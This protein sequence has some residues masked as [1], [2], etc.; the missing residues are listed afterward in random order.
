[1][2]KATGLR[3]AVEN[4]AYALAIAERYFGAAQ[5]VDDFVC[6]TLGTGVGGGCYSNGRLIRG[7]HNLANALGHI[8]IQHKGL[9]CSCGQP[10]CLETYANAKALVRYAGDR[11]LTAEDVIRAANSGEKAACEALRIY[12]GYL[13]TGIVSIIQM[14]DPKLLILSGGLVQDNHLLFTYVE[15]EVRSMLMAQGERQFELR[16]SPL[17]YYG[18]VLGAAAAAGERLF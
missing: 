2:Q 6:L 5:G 1:L 13:A 8:T 10:G 18:G 12:S 9:A 3:V 16:P 4:D 17:G 14:L 15:Q 11:F 7:A